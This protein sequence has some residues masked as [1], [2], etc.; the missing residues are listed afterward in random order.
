MRRQLHRDKNVIFA[1]YQIP[2]PLEYKL[3]VKVGSLLQSILLKDDYCE[4][5]ART[6]TRAGARKFPRWRF[7]LLELDFCSANS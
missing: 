6:R 7:W 4:H 2:H 1:G 3:I 5:C